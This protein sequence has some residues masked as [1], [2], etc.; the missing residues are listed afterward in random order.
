[1]NTIIG[2]TIDLEDK[3]VD[4]LDQAIKEGLHKHHRIDK[5]YPFDTAFRMSG[6]YSQA[7]G[8]IYIKGSPEHILAKSKAT[9]KEQQMAESIMHEFA[10]GVYFEIWLLRLTGLLP[11]WPAS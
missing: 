7:D 10:I 6:A 2:R 11:E 9:K 4:P 5:L 1:M 3:I 8:L